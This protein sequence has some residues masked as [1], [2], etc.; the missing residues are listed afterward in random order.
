MSVG[1]AVLHFYP[2]FPVKLLCV[3]GGGLHCYNHFPEL[4]FLCVWGGGGG[5]AALFQTFTW[6][7]SNVGPQHD[8]PNQTS[9]FRLYTHS[10]SVVLPL[11]VARALMQATGRQSPAALTFGLWEASK[12]CPPY[13]ERRDAEKH[14]LE[15]VWMD[16]AGY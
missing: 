2:H 10:W 3:L 7:C 8:M 9:N 5:G 11:E 15:G 1:G 4:K 6:M 13:F 16:G 12:D 14:V